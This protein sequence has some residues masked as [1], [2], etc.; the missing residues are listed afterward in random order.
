MMVKNM[1]GGGVFGEL[2]SVEGDISMMFGFSFIM[3]FQSAERRL[4]G[5][6]P[7]V[8][9]RPVRGPFCLFIHK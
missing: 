6:S 4:G 5:E 7:K 8:M 9:K 1:V 2:T 3:K